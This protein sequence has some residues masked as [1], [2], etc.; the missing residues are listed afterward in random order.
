MQLSNLEYSNLNTQQQPINNQNQNQNQNQN[1]F[2][3]I[4]T[5][6]ANKNTIINIAKYCGLMLILGYSIC[7]IVDIKTNKKTQTKKQ[8]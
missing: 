2:N 4:E 6:K 3:C 5:A 7:D 1:N 8:K